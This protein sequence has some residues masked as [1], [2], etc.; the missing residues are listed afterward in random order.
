[1]CGKEKKA[2]SIEDFSDVFAN[3]VVVVVVVSE[4]SSF[5]SS[6]PSFSEDGEDIYL[7]V[8]IVLVVEKFE[9][10]AHGKNVVMNKKR[11]ISEG[12][13]NLS[14]SLSLSLSL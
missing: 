13:K 11:R 14:L 6:S 4:S 1:L 2:V 5:S 12:T 8:V 9:G 7:F 10:A 3:K